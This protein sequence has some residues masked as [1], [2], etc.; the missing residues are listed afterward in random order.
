MRVT[1]NDTDFA[2]VKAIKMDLN[3][4][5]DELWKQGRVAN[6]RNT[7]PAQV[8]FEQFERTLKERHPELF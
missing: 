7:L 6:G 8:A 5:R 4:L 3:K 1:G 2:R